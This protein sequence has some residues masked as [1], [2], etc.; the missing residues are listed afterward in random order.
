M[1]WM[2]KV[3]M[4]YYFVQE[5]TEAGN[6]VLIMQEKENLSPND[7]LLFSSWVPFYKL[8]PKPFSKLIIEDSPPLVITSA[9]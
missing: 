3:S 2:Y 6:P 9:S 7:N 8:V 5:G 1:T 4:S